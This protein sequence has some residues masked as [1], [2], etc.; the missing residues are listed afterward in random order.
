MK[1]VIADKKDEQFPAPPAE[2]AAGRK[3]EAARGSAGIPDG[4][5]H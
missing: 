2:A 3:G 5:S 4:K 1:A